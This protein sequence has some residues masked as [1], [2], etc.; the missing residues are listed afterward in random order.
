MMK[1]TIE[2]KEKALVKICDSHRGCDECPID[3]FVNPGEK[4]MR[5]KAWI[6]RMYSTLFP[7]D[8]P[9]KNVGHIIPV[10]DLYDEDGADVQNT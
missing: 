7:E 10:N 8:V 4:C 9:D 6:E 3:A 5:D 1:M 2:D